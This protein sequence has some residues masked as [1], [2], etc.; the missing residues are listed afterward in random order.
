MEEALNPV[1]FKDL[2]WSL[3]KSL[4]AAR[5]SQYRL[6]VQ[7]DLWMI[8]SLMLNEFNKQ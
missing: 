4:F 1:K 6:Y 5:V 2:E 8:H 3:F 7:M